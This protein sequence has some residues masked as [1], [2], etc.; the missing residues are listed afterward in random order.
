MLKNLKS[1]KEVQ[2]AEEKRILKRNYGIDLLRLLCM[3]MVVILHVNGQGGVLGELVDKGE[4]SGAYEA[5]WLLEIA[6]FCAVDCFALISGFIGV[7]TKFKVNRIIS[8]WFSIVWWT[9]IITAGFRI[10]NIDTITHREW[11]NAIMPVTNKQYWY[12]TAYFGMFF[13]IPY[14]NKMFSVLE[15]RH[16][17]CLGGSIIALSI[18]QTIIR[19][20]IFLLKQGYSL[21]WLLLLYLLGGVIKKLEYNFQKVKSRI[22]LIIYLGSVLVTWGWKYIGDGI[23]ADHFIPSRFIEYTS[24]TILICAITLLLFFKDL[25]INAF[26]EK[27]ISLSVAGAFG[28]Y[29]I[30]TNPLIYDRILNHRFDHIAEYCGRY[31]VLSVIMWAM[32]IFIGCLLVERIRISIFKKLKINR[33]AC[34]CEEKLLVVLEFIEKKIGGG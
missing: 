6:A 15:K 33:I 14:F 32:L 10:L 13:F 11:M 23:Y 20:D 21:L 5:S 16:L 3:F 31:L 25:K 17:I 7:D 18:Y 19:E 8:L 29:I 22:W 1:Y 30:H 34:W 26:W 4:I 24:P 9:L 2:R 28:V 12:F 27:V